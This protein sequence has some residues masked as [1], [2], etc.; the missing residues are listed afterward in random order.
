MTKR[1]M[2]SVVALVAMFSLVG[3]VA[4]ASAHHGDSD[5]AER[6][7]EILGIPAE[8]VAAALQQARTEA[9]A[10]RIAAVLSEA[11]EAGVITQVD[12]DAISDWKA[13]KPDALKSIKHHGLR[14]AIQTGEVEAFLSDLVTQGLITQTE[15]DEI[16]AW[17][18][19]RPDSVDS[20]R[21]WR[22]SQ[23]QADGH[24]HH[25]RGHGHGCVHPDL[26]PTTSG[27][28]SDSA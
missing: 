9:R 11:V 14:T 3:G 24:R 19:I 7:A 6:L 20:V 15:S 16:T 28:V 27:D 13:G 5:K 21:E 1:I 8:D 2:L 10:E 17:L 4:M 12:A 18:T 25:K 22:K 26:T 23:Y